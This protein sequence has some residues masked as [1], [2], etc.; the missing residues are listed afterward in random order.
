MAS[1]D[2]YDILGIGRTATADDVRR[3]HRKLALQYHPDRNKA[4]DAPAKF[5]EIQEA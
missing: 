2:L 1:R 5:A 4:K 3:A